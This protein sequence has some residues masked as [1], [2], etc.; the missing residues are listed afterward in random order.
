MWIERATRKVLLAMAHP[1]A[2]DA[3]LEDGIRPPT[4]TSVAEKTSV[5]RKLHAAC[6]ATWPGQ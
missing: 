1:A 2:K 3:R 6:A 5:S 4:P